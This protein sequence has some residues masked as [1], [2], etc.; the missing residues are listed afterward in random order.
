[1]SFSQGI[2]GI[3]LNLENSNVGVAIFG[4]DRDIKEGDLVSRTGNV[5]SVPVGEELLGRVIDPLGN[6][7]DDLGPI[8]F[9]KKMNVENAAPGL[10]Q[11]KSVHEPILTGIKAIDNLVPIG[12]G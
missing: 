3:A 9:S 11:R 1:M 7:L 12:K 4:N 6:P 2:Q 10:I 8:N 5:I